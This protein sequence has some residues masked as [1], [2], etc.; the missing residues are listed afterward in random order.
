MTTDRKRR[1]DIPLR[2]CEN[3][4]RFEGSANTRCPVCP[5]PVWDESSQRFVMG[6][7]DQPTGF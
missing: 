1:T 2:I 3:G 7:V 4:H 6:F 5:W